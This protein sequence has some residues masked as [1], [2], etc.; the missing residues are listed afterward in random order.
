ML[1][2][3]GSLREMSLDLHGQILRNLASF[4]YYQIILGTFIGAAMGGLVG[5]VPTKFR[6]QA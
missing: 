4:G 3:V 1:V 2:P 6:R 5:R